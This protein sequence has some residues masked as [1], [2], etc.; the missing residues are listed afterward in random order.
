[1]L[2]AVVLGIPLLSAIRLLVWGLIIDYAAVLTLAFRRPQLGVLELSAHRLEL[3]APGSGILF[4]LIAGTLCGVLLAGV[5]PLYAVLGF[6]ADSA[7]LEYILFAGGVLASF[8]AVS[9][10]LFAGR[11]FRIHAAY[12][13][14]ALLIAAVLA[15]G[16][17]G[18][19]LA[20]DTATLCLVL[21][22]LLPAAVLCAL[23]R[24]YRHTNNT[25]RTK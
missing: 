8:A 20:A 16:A 23:C 1:M 22:A 13:V 17:L 9:E 5:P 7:A 10:C 14:C 21:L 15:A 11:G 2:A 18:A 25:Y 24:I 6:A 4:P 12:L 3:P 19:G